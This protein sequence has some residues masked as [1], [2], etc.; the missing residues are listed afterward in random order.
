MPDRSL[1]FSCRS[2]APDLLSAVALLVV[3]NRVYQHE[4][5]L[6]RV[7]V[8]QPVAVHYEFDLFPGWFVH[9]KS[10]GVLT[11]VGHAVFCSHPFERQDIRYGPLVEPYV[12]VILH[13]R[14]LIRGQL[15]AISCDGHGLVARP[16]SGDEFSIT[17]KIC[18]RLI[19]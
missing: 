18:R 11:I 16:Y 10:R 2:C 6:A 13:E 17:K 3:F 12:T 1:K 8:V 19:V 5:S 4:F 15:P 7:V 9:G 14:F